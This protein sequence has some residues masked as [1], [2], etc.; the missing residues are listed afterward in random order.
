M[1]RF[2]LLTL[3]IVLVIAF[4]ISAFT[5]Q[6]EQKNSVATSATFPK[7]SKNTSADSATVYMTTDISPDGLMAIYEALGRK[8]EGKVAVKLHSGEPGGHYYLTPDLIKDLVQT[9]NGT[10]VECNTAYGGSRASTAM[11]KQVMI[12]HGF[13]A[14]ATTDIMD[15]EG[16]ISLPVPNGENI[17][18]DFVGSHLLNYD[19]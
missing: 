11:H 17:E 13:T 1:K 3:P 12:D 9:V 10:I 7:T 18:E 16:Y 6:Y 14:I 19:F 4:I 2:L 8:A 15:E 5:K